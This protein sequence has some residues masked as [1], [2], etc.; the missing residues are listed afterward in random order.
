M[1]RKRSTKNKQRLELGSTLKHYGMSSGSDT[2][3]G[4]RNRKRQIQLN[5]ET[6][7]QEQRAKR[8]GKRPMVPDEKKFF[9]YG[10]QSHDQNKAVKQSH[11]QNK[12]VK[13]VRIR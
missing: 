13:Q 11:D 7:S 5:H 3:R 6:I 12:A 9:G 2:S 8:E 4:Y 1:V 10:F